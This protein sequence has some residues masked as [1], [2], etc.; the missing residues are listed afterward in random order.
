MTLN[1]PILAAA[2]ALALCVYKVLIYP[3]FLSPLSKIP[4]AH[5]SS[6]IC[7]LWIYY[8]RHQQIE[9]QT[10]HELHKKKGPIV[11]TAPNEL[12]VNCY[13]GGLKTI[14]TGGFHKTD[15]YHHRFAN[16]GWVIST[17][18]VP[19]LQTLHQDI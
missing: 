18:T 4:S 7:P 8:I 6:H 2:G 11:R 10:I 13:E 15:Y 5:W 3:L 12:S 14:Y 17:P 9:N 16:Y 1:V 19:K